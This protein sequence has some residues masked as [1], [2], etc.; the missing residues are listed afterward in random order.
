MELSR[1]ISWHANPHQQASSAAHLPPSIFHQHRIFIRSHLSSTALM[2]LS[3]NPTSN[4]QQ[5]QCVY[6]KDADGRD[7]ER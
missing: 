6:P 5:A 3:R 4:V 2:H 7:A 1:A